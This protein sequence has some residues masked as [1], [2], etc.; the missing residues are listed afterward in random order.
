MTAEVWQGGDREPV[1]CGHYAIIDSRVLGETRRLL[2]YLP[3][4]YDRGAERYPVLIQLDG[5]KEVFYQSAM[6]VWYLANMAERIPEHIVVAIEN[7]DRGRDMAL[8]RGA[9]AFLQ[10]IEHELVPYLEA[11][12]RT[13]GRRI[14]YGLS[15]SSVFAC[16][17]FL[18]RPRL[19]EACVLSSFGLGDRD[20]AFLDGLLPGLRRT[21]PPP[22]YLF[23]A[24]PQADA[25]DPQGVRA[26]GARR[27]VD[28]L[29]SAAA[30]HITLQSKTY[31]EEGH[32]PY[33]SLYDGLKWLYGQVKN[34]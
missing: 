16:Y 2:V 7:T 27:F 24:N 3:Q 34:E 1:S 22:R 14:L 28:A 23:V 8:D 20:G 25:Y 31:A 6:V 9:D 30:G 4:S 18:K 13:S 12:Y 11:N 32:V 10:F 5:Y 33:P 26:G 29:S 17:A 21:E 19:F 15:A